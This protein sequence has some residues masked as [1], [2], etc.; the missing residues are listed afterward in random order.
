MQTQQATNAY[1]LYM[2]AHAAYSNKSLIQVQSETPP[3]LFE[4]R[5][6]TLH[7]QYMAGEFSFGRFTEL[8]GVPH[9]E[10]WQILELL[11]LALHN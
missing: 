10:L 2:E 6:R 5:V 11:D 8:L 9:W 4:S 1:D 7:Q 3:D